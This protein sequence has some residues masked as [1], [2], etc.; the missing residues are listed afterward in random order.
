MYIYIYNNLYSWYTNSSVRAFFSRRLITYWFVFF[1]PYG[2]VDSTCKQ[3][4]LL[5]AIIIRT[6]NT[7]NLINRFLLL[8]SER[9]YFFR[10]SVCSVRR[11]YTIVMRTLVFLF[12]RLF[13]RRRSRSAARAVGLPALPPPRHPRHRLDFR[14]RYD[15]HYCLIGSAKQSFA[16]GANTGWCKSIENPKICSARAVKLYRLVISRTKRARARV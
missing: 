7:G 4:R 12:L 11:V 5:F 9:N 16:Y 2:T 3:S 10:L 8:P 6:H 14:H 13:R 15:L 1:S